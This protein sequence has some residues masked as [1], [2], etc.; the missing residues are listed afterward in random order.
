MPQSKLDKLRSKLEE[1][2]NKKE[3]LNVVIKKLQVQIAEE[4]SRGFRSVIEELELSYEDA[5]LL[6]KN[7]PPQVPEKENEVLVIQEEEN[8]EGEENSYESI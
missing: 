1:S 2:Q 5:I 3:Q 4:E 7:H 8:I 6:L